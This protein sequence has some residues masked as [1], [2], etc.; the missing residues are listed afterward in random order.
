M[1]KNSDSSTDDMQN[2]QQG[3]FSTPELTVDTEKLAQN[4]EVT[5]EASRAKIA[6]IFANTETGQQAQ[7]LNDAMNVGAEH[8]TEDIVIDSG[9]KKKSKVPIIMAIVALALIAV[10]VGAWFLVQNLGNQ[11]KETP[12]TAFN[13]YREYLEKGPELKDN[14]DDTNRWY[15]FE[16]NNIGLSMKDRQQYI[17]DLEKKYQTYLDLLDKQTSSAG[18]LALIKAESQ[19]YKVKLSLVL[20]LN[21]LDLVDKELLSVYAGEGAGE[22]LGFIAAQTQIETQDTFVKQLSSKLEEYLQISFTINE[23]YNAHGCLMDDTIDYLCEEQLMSDNL[24]YAQ[25][26]QTQNTVL[27]Q[28][29]QQLAIVNRS[30]Q[31]ETTSIENELGAI[32][33]N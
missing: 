2:T 3:I 5:K 31:I 8:V 21:Y 13:S 26:L 6:S 24:T 23:L 32:Y 18:N 20:K 16:M 9:R 17:A 4:A 7:K 29:M 15:V 33:E 19:N 10:G 1:D 27:G 30:I 12:L 25:T 22:A 11:S 28:L 14:E